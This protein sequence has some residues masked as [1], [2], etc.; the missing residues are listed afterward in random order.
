ML[1][2][3]DILA[4][5][6]GAA[7]GAM[8]ENCQE[9]FATRVNQRISV[10]MPESFEYL[11]LKSGLIQSKELSEILKAPSDYIDSKEYES[12]ERYFTQLLIKMTGD[13]PY[14]YSKKVLDAYYLQ[15]KNVQKV[16]ENFPNVIKS[17]FR[18]K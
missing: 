5:V 8:I 17:S 9:Y 12:W 6:D 15:E 3:G 13:K 10:W 11:V 7:F 16:A 2:T 1:K 14:K 18:A 4:I